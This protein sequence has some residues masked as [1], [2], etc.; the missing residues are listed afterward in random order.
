MAVYVTRRKLLGA[1]VLFMLFAGVLLMIVLL[2]L[3]VNR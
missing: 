2:S 1:F 3:T